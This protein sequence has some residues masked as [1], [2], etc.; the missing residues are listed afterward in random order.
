MPQTIPKAIAAPIGMDRAARYQPGAL[1]LA[2]S[3]TEGD[4]PAGLALKSALY[5]RGTLRLR[6][7][8]GREAARRLELP[9]LGRP[10]LELRPRHDV[11][12]LAHGRVA[13][14]AQLRADDVI[15]ADAVGCGEDVGG[16]A[17]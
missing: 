15:A 5:L 2:A 14:A 13:Q 4:L 11:G 6:Q 8:L 9:L 7:R 16:D 17:G 3:V 1:S 10:L 12:E